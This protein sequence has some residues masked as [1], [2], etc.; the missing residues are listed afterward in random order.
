MKRSPPPALALTIALLIASPTAR[1]VDTY[2]MDP[3]HTSVIFSV[4]H[5][6][7]SFTY[8]MFRETA[9]LYM[10]DKLNPANCKFNFVIQANSLFTNNSDR[11]ERLRSPDFFNVQAFPE[12]SFVTTRCELTNTQDG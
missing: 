10:I 7:L 3:E 12:T 6:G 1:A 2:K 8:G 5:A 9:G 4:A 11:D